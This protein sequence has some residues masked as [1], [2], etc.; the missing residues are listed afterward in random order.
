[1]QFNLN[2]KT[3]YRKMKMKKQNLEIKLISW[4]PILMFL[5]VIKI[6]VS[7][8]QLLKLEIDRYIGLPIFVLIFK[9]FTIIKTDNQSF[10]FFFFHIHNYTEYNQ[11]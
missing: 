8:Q 1:M 4:V 11:Q 3:E 2:I 6:D 5:V 10:F 9:H 7:E